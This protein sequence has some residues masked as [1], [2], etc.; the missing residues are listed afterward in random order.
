M[1]ASLAPLACRVGSSADGP[2][3]F[4]ELTIARKKFAALLDTG[5]SASLF[6]DEVLA[7]LHQNKVHLR[8]CGTTFR[9]AS[10]TAQSSG[11]ARLVVRWERRVRRQRLVHLPGLTV[12]IILGRDF[13]TKTGIVLDIANGGYRERATGAL[14]IFVQPP[15]GTEATRPAKIAQAGN[16]RERSQRGKWPQASGAAPTKGTTAV[17]TGQAGQG[18][19]A[20]ESCAAVSREGTHPLLSAES[21]LTKKEQARL[22]SLLYE[23]DAM[24][25]DRPG[26]TKLVKHRIDTG[27][28]QP[29]KCN[30]R[31]ISQTKRRGLDSALDELLQTG[32][33]R[34]SDSPWGFPVVLVEKKDGT[35][36]LC[37]DYRRL[38][39]FT[40]KDAYPLPDISS[41]VSNLGGAKYFTTLDAS[42]GYFQVEMDERDMEKTAFTCHR[43]LF[44]FTRMSFGLVGAPATYQRLMDRV[45]G[46]AKWQHALAYLD[47]VVVYS[48]TF[49]E[50]LEHLRD[51]LERLRSA[52]ITLNP[53]K[54]QIAKT[55]IELLGFTID[56]GRILPSADKLRAL[57]EFPSPTD[58][59]GLRRFLGM[60][61]FYRQ[62]IPDCAALQAPLTKLLKKGE[63]W[64]WGPEQES[65]L[66]KL[67][68]VLADT[69]ELQL[70]DLNREFVIQ[71]DACDLGLGAVLLQEHEGALRPVAFASRSLTPAERNYSVTEKE[72]LAIVFALR[73]FDY[74][75]DGVPFVI[76]TDHM[77]LTWLRRLNEPSGR[78]ARWALLLQRYDF[79]VRYR[80]GKNN[81]VADALSR[82]PVQSEAGTHA[83]H[84]EPSSQAEG[85]NKLR[86]VGDERKADSPPIPGG[87]VNHVDVVSPVGIAFSRRELLEAQQRDSFC[88]QVFDGLREP[89]GRA[90][91]HKGAA[92]IAV[93]AERFVTAS[94]AVS[95]LDSYLL[96]SDGVLLRYI[97]SE[98]DTSESFK[99]V[100]P[101]TLQGALLRYFHDTCIAGHASGPK[102]YLKL[103]RFATWIGM[104]RDA[105]RYARTCHVCQS[106]K[107]R[108]GRPPG[109]MQPIG[110]QA[111]W[112]I[113]ACD[114]M[115]PYPI[116]PGRN[117]FLLVVTDHFS[118]WVELFPLRKLTAQVI[119]GKL[120]EVFTRFG[121]PE[122]LITD[123]ASYFTAKVFVDSCAALGIKHRKTTTYHAQSN[124]TERVNRNVKHMLVAFAEEHRDW[125]A[126]I[127]E[128]GFALR[129]T[130]NRSTGYAP[131]SLNL[132][133]ELLNPM[134]RILT[135]R[136]GAPVVSSAPAEY[137]T[138]LRAR[139]T[140]ALLN[141]RHNLS[142][143]RAQQKAQ[144]DRSH[145]EVRYE[146]GDFVLR[147]NHVLSDASKH[148]AASLAKKWTGPY[149]VRE[150]VSSLV[151]RLADMKGKPTGGPVHV[152]DLKRYAARGSEWGENALT[153][154]R[155]AQRRKG[156]RPASPVE[157]YDLRN[158]RKH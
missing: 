4:I 43:G 152:C 156:G 143:A 9:L 153:R 142:T 151:Y 74:Y 26:C 95:A 120:M 44:E 148:F 34:R 1:N 21:S 115:G 14:K 50:H 46:D 89:G 64:S 76:E 113:V 130:V 138:K 98:N 5:A 86:T 123:N 48:K 107:P 103:C 39:E 53:A 79:T 112:Q 8:A 32:V 102:T 19:D 93:S 59:S 58:L 68:R 132:G 24:F 56:R 25:T 111:P 90:A 119:M 87:S 91:A 145:R 28:A 135:D 149:Q 109:L 16:E 121:F 3:P 7:H 78:L 82:A 10:G 118:K 104:R 127:S 72:C 124:P 92:G 12:P 20:G 157:R 41:L 13:L 38:N 45:L 15:A 116:T 31:P 17:E 63:P 139:L 106:V 77:A 42:R 88:R 99:V 114:I 146:V 85:G 67:V 125:D 158:R 100:I 61:N 62:F 84:A 57:L 137:A 71:T 33:V 51:V 54:A 66:R 128:L 73:K 37:V 70:P 97:P 154:R 101:R 35:F 117:K 69:A 81:V 27:D 2:A 18:G 65:A 147:R 140:E 11:A 40:R 134:E 105:I 55:R 94:N 126:H 150:K 141:A 36:R 47:D 23:Y 108:G 60:A 30:P 75:V 129:T 122:Q 22:S 133:R 83:R 52:G 80:K 131:V 144:Y 136:S 29:W 6:G 49:E 110:S 155:P 96:D